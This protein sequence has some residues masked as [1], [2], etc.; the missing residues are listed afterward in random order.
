MGEQLDPN[1]SGTI[2][3]IAQA[4]EKIGFPYSENMRKKNFK[5]KFSASFI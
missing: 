5:S 2:Y 1:Q 4:E 3:F